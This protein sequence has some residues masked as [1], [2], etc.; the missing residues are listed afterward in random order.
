M[1][2]TAGERN[3]CRNERNIP[4]SGRATPRLA[5]LPT[6][7]SVGVASRRAWIRFCLERRTSLHQLHHVSRC[8]AVFDIYGRGHTID[9]VGLDGLRFALA[10]PVEGY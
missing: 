7:S 10:R 9:P 1:T 2:T 8:A 3:A 4:K 5:G 6:G